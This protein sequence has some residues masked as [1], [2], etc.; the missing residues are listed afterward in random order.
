MIVNWLEMRS[1]LLY[2]HHSSEG[3]MHP[4]DDVVIHR[5]RSVRLT[6]AKLE[7]PRDC[8]MLVSIVAGDRFFFGSPQPSRMN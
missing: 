8:P 5:R 3:R 1:S 7:G 4:D 6:L 2:R